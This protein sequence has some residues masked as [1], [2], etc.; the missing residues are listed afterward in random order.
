MKGIVNNAGTK[1]TRLTRYKHKRNERGSPRCA[2]T[3]HFLLSICYPVS[4]ATPQERIRQFKN[5]ASTKRHSTRK[6]R[7]SSLHSD[8]IPNFIKL[9]ANRPA[10]RRTQN[11]KEVT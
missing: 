6:W 1:T 2:R 8:W 5:D 7:G 10:M 3:I 4:L 9:R 11:R